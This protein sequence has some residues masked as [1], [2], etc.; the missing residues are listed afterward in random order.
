MYFRT[1]YLSPQTRGDNWAW[2]QTATFLCSESIYLQL[3]QPGQTGRL[4]R[5]RSRFVIELYLYDQIRTI[6]KFSSPGHQS[7]GVSEA[8][9]Q[10]REAGSRRCLVVYR[11]QDKTL[12]QRLADTAAG[13]QVPGR[14]GGQVSPHPLVPEGPLLHAGH[15]RPG[16]LPPPPGRQH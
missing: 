15:P 6:L 5:L 8:L 11:Q 9:H 7:D 10:P 3:I 4:L 16:G 2:T 13:R 14:P 1:F 12:I